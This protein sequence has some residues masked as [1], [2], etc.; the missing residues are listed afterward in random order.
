VEAVI[1]LDDLADRLEELEFKVQW[2]EFPLFE[3]ERDAIVF[4]LRN[5]K[6]PAETVKS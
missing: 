1:D 4:A 2:A 5:V 6:P 3:E